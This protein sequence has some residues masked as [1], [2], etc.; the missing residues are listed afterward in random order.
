MAYKEKLITE[1]INDYLEYIECED[2]EREFLNQDELIRLAQ[3]PCDSDVLRRAS[4]FS[5]LTGLR[6]SDILNLRWNNIQEVAGIGLCVVLKTQK[7]KTPATLPLCDD[8]IE[9]IGERQTG[10]VFVGFKKTLTAKPLKEWIKSAKI[11]K[12]ITFHC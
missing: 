12:R 5:C 6:F 9:L 2:I 3:T 4:L 10:K 11:D 8:A 7:T 1:N